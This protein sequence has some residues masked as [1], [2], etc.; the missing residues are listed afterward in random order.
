MAAPVQT[1]RHS[2]GI[3][4]ADVTH[5]NLE[6]RLSLLL[7]SLTHPLQSPGSAIHTGS[8]R[9]HG[10]PV[11]NEHNSQ[12][13]DQGS[14]VAIQADPTLLVGHHLGSFFPCRVELNDPPSGTAA[15]CSIKE[16]GRRCQR[17]QQIQA[18]PPVL[19]SVLHLPN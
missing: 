11:H 18:V 8:G 19:T 2:N 13:L 12:A 3:H 14:Q 7:R 15:M 1:R 4:T 9:I 6:V 5:P 17:P 10:R 16:L